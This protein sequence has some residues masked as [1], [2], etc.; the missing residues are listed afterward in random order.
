MVRF[1]IQYRCNN[2]CC[3]RLWSVHS[4]P[5]KR[6]K[7]VC[8]TTY[9]VRNTF[10]HQ[11]SSWWS[12]ARD[13]LSHFH[14]PPLGAHWRPFLI[15]FCTLKVVC[16]CLLPSVSGSLLA[17]SCVVSA[18]QPPRS[19]PLCNPPVSQSIVS[20]RSYPCQGLNVRAHDPHPLCVRR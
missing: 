14:H 20:I 18:D 5:L 1:L 13:A 11:R 8:N 17:A 2:L 7:S 6:S 4:G 12:R 3:L 15:R 9:L 10:S 16:P 19:S